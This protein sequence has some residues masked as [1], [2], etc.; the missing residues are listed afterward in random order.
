MSVDAFRQ[1]AAEYAAQA[2]TETDPQKVGMFRCVER[3][4]L[5][6]ARNE[7]RIEEVSSFLDEI[8][9]FL[10]EREPVA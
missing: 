3:G 6:A 9:A 8:R 4:W 2:G 5:A 7:Q 10:N 1:T